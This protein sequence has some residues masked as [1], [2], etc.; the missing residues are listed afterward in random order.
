LTDIFPHPSVW[1]EQTYYARINAQA[2]LDAALADPSFYGD[3]AAHLALFN[4]HG[5]V[6]VRDVAQQVLRVLD[7]AHGTVIAWREGERIDDF[8]KSYGVLL[9]YLH[10]IGMIDFRPFGRAMHPE[11]ASQ[12]VF[13]P[14]FDHVVDAL[15]QSDC[16]GIAS[17]L[18]TLASAG[19][20]AQ[21]PRLVLRELLAMANCHSK[22]KVPVAILNDQH[23][24][25]KH[26]QQTIAEDVQV[27]YHRY[28]VERA[29]TALARAEQVSSLRLRSLSSQTH[30][31]VPRR[32]WHRLM[33]QA[34]WPRVAAPASAATT[35][36]STA[37]RSSGCLPSTPQCACW[38]PM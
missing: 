18:R 22:S 37:T 24:L 2:Q 5:V 31:A 35:P 4:D 9:A 8:M 23:L 27:L 28:Q 15:W 36:I 34:S 19:A 33:R 17:R 13:D 11:F 20:L 30:C 25:R 38:W 6:H 7:H 12:A 14:A 16:G 32:L 29:R 10:D 21:H 3:P 26:M 1:V